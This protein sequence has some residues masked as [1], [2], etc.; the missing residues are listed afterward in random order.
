HPHDPY[1][2][3]PEF[4]DLYP[5]ANVDM[6][7]NPRRADDPHSTRV[8]QGNEGD[9][10][11]ASE[12]DILSARRGYYANTSYFD[13]NVGIL[14]RTLEEAGLIDNTVVIVTSDHGDMLGERDLWYK[15]SW[16]DHSSRVPLVMA[17]PGVRPG[18]WDA[19]CSLIDL[20]PTMLDIADAEHPCHIPLDGRSL[21]PSATER[22]PGQTEAIGEYCAE[23]APGAPVIMLRRDRWKY[24]HAAGDPPQLYD[25]AADPDELTNLAPDHPV[26][27]DFAVEVAARWNDATVSAQVIASQDR[28]RVIT[29]ALGQGAPT[30][31]DYTPPRDASQEYVRNHMDW[32]VAAAKNRWPPNPHLKVRS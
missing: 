10:I 29:G 1:V 21:W 15:M 11:A 19:P 14:I 2:A 13:H 6:P 31:W 5:D 16:F 12:A 23:C 8:R 22:A 25:L 3:R 17:G 18:T 24:I 7:K 27:H 32:T 30:H 26:A 9:R 28:R 20:F 4:W